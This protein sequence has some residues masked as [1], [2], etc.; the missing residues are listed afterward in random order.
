VVKAP[1]GSTAS[2]DSERT[3]AL[4]SGIGAVA[5]LCGCPGCR[6]YRAAW[7]AD[8]LDE[9]LLAACLEIG[10]DPSKAFET[11]VVG[12]RDP[13]AYTAS[14]PFF[15]SVVCEPTEEVGFVPWSFSRQAFGT[16]NVAEGVVTINFIVTLPWVLSEPNPYTS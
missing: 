12:E 4:Y 1:D 7:R 8:Y 10:I 9:A 6:N 16:A 2:Y 3:S 15:G 13:L 11:T 14:L 5:D